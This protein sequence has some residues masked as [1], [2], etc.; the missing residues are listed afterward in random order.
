MKPPIKLEKSAY[1]FLEAGQK[2]FRQLEVSSPHQGYL[3][4]HEPG[5]FWSSCLNSDVSNLGKR[6][7]TIAREKD[8]YN[9]A[10]GDQANFKRYWLPNR[11]AAEEALKLVNKYRLKRGAGL[12][13]VNLAQMLLEQF[14]SNGIGEQ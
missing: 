7:I 2:G 6:G 11:K 3:F 1:A 10:D 12:L 5:L 4:K 13:P 14:P 8:P 9:R